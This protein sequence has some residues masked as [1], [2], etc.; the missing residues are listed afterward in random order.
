MFVGVNIGT[1]RMSVINSK[2]VENKK[3]KTSLRLNAP[4][5]WSLKR[6][7]LDQRRNVTELAEEA[8]SDLLLK[9]G[10]AG[11]QTAKD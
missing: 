6:L 9:Y 4:I 10:Y 8:F 5:F 7:G 3:V 1:R 2:T 11:N